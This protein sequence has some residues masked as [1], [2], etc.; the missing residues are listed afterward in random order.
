MASII[1]KSVE[2]TLA[3][4]TEPATHA[5]ETAT[6]TAST[7][8]SKT[9]AQHLATKTPALAAKT[10]EQNAAQGTPVT[11]VTEKIVHTVS[12]KKTIPTQLLNAL[13]EQTS[14]LTT[15]QAASSSL[16]STVATSTTEACFQDTAAMPK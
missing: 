5:I 8:V 6:V 7:V 9:T 3:K 1:G 16:T 13:E 15:K 4:I 12:K 10:F 2:D 11:S 14:V